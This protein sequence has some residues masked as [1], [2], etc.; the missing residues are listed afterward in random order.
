[1]NVLKHI[2]VLIQDTEPGPSLELALRRTLKAM[3]NYADITTTSLGL[4][5]T[6]GSRMTIWRSDVLRRLFE[7]YK[8]RG[9]NA[10]AEEFAQKLDFLREKLDSSD[11]ETTERLAQSLNRTSR[12]MRNVLSNIPLPSK[13]R[14]SLHFTDTDPFPSIHRAMLNRNAKVVRFLCESTR[15]ILEDQED[16]LRRGTLHLAAETANEEVLGRLHPQ[17]QDLLGKRDKCM[18]T[19]LSYCGPTRRLRFL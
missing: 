3:E 14:S 4:D 7:I 1:M 12:H 19:P 10:E 5:G 15:Q 17:I 13:Y 9:D 6:T 8:T 18:K 16:I 2:L 11:S